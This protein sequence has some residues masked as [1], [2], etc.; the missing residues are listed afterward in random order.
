MPLTRS[1]AW[2]E[3]AASVAREP[4]LLTLEFQHPSFI[5]N[6]VTV[7]IRVVADMADQVFRIESGASLNPNADVTFT[8]V[9]FDFDPP[10]LGENGGA[11]WTVRVDNIGR[12]VSKYLADATG[13]NA[14]LVVILRG[15]LT[16]ARTVVGYGPFRGVARS[17]NVSG[18]MA[19]MTVTIADPQGQKFGR[20]TYD[21]TRFPSLLAIQL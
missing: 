1:Q 3:A 4:M 11:E 7:P 5:E 18:S 9:P 2:A 13:I 6:G 12:E 15:Y 19:E 16:S 10:K 20:D 17:V 8:A 14:E 21:Q